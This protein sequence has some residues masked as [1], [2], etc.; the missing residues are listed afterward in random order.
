MDY[1]FIGKHRKVFNEK[2]EKSYLD[3][4]EVLAAYDAALVEVILTIS[5]ERC[6]AL[7]KGM[8]MVFSAMEKEKK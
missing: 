1:N 4:R 7:D 6:A 8:D 5:E 2:M 3:K